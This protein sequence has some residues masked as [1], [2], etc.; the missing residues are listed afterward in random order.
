MTADELL[1]VN[2]SD[3]VGRS[4][5]RGKT[6]IAHGSGHTAF[7]DF[8]IPADAPARQSIKVRYLVFHRQDDVVGNAVEP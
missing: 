4:V 1:F 6:G 7:V 5:T 8:E 3:S 2:C